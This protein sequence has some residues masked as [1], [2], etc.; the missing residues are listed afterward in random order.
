MSKS[1]E[2]EIKTKWEQIIDLFQKN[3]DIESKRLK[4]RLGKD[5]LPILLV[6][7]K[8]HRLQGAQIVVEFEDKTILSTSELCAADVLV[9]FIEKVGVD[10]VQRLGITDRKH[11]PLVS[12]SI[13]GIEHMGP[14]EI[15]GKFVITKTG[16]KEKLDVIR[17]IIDKLKCPAEVK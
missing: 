7:D 13:L 14:K 11:H 6:V 10:E 4:L 1:V 12:D 3:Y 9:R 16:N 5:N 15:E 17:E 8:A 2:S